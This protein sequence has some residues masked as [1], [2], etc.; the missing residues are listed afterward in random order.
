[1]PGGRN[2]ISP[3]PSRF[4]APIW[5]RIVRLSILL[6]TWKAMRVG[7]LALIRPVMTSTLGRWVARIKWI[8]A[9]RA[10][11]A[12][13]AISSSI[14]LPAV[15][16]KSANSSTT[17]TINGSFS[18]GSG[19]SGVRLNGLPIFSPRAAASAIFW[20]KPARLRTPIKLIRR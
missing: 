17:T 14:F 16:I 13:R 8:P 2:S 19:F 4:S 15:I 20:L 6:D 9:A 1:M 11:W 10:F 12:R 3:W 18:N 7:I 5:S